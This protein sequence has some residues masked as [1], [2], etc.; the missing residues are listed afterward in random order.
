MVES[1]KNGKQVSD[2]MIT[3]AF[4]ALRKYDKSLT[5]TVTQETAPV[6]LNYASII[7]DLTQLQD[8]LQICALLQAL[9]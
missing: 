5:F 6:S 8:D 9:R 2:G 3:Q 4:T 7:K 1:T